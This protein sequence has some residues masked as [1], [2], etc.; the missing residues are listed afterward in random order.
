MLYGNDIDEDTTPLEAP[1]KW[2]VKW[3]KEF[4]GKKALLDKKPTKKLVGFEVKEGRIARH[5]NQVMKNGVKCG[6]VTSGSFSP[7]LK[8][9]IGF[10]FVPID[11]ETDQLIEIE[12]GGKP[13]EAKVCNTRFYKKQIKAL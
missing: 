12:I 2:T 4:I 7:T 10:C 9:S 6:L 1:L 5:G 11:V 3:E 8:K 13:Y